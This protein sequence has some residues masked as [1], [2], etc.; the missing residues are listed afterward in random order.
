MKIKIIIKI[1]LFIIKIVNLYFKNKQMNLKIMKIH[2]I[3]KKIFSK[4]SQKGKFV[5]IFLLYF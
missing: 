2:T 1:L 5:K 4:N 3:I